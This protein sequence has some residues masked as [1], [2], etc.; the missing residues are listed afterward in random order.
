MADKETIE[1][2]DGEDAL[3]KEE[4]AIPKENSSPEVVEKPVA[5]VSNESEDTQDSESLQKE[6]EGVTDRLQRQVAEF[7][8][9]RRRTEQEKGQMVL[10]GKSMVIQQLLDVFDDFHR[11]IEAS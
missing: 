10:F 2:L 7:Q 9:Y 4:E 3:Q 11:S 6:L 5:P 8:N 1:T